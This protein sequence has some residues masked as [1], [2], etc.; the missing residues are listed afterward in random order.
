MT[1]KTA[2]E[3]ELRAYREL[4]ARMSHDLRAQLGIVLGFAEL[5]R[6]R[7]LDS[8]ERE[9]VDAIHAAGREMLA[10]LDDLLTEGQALARN[11]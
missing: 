7:D 11:A 1:R 4:F 8:E 5:L 9:D 6:D 10:L 2:A 3:R